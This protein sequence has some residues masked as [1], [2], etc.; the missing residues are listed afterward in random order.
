MAKKSAKSK[1]YRKSAPKKNYLSKKELTITAIVAAVVI[2][3]LVLFIG[4]Y[5]DGSLKVSGG[6]VKSSGENSLIV[7]AGTGYKPRYFQLGNLAEIDG[8]TLTVSPLDS[9]GNVNE[10]IYTP[11]SESPIDSI[12]VRT[13][14]LDAA[15]Y[16]SASAE[17]YTTDPSMNC[18][19]LHT[20][21]DDGHAV[22][23][24]TF[25]VTPSTNETAPTEL[26][27]SIEELRDEIEA[28][29]VIDEEEQATLELLA[30]AAKPMLAQALHGYID[31][32]ENRLIYVLIRNDVETEQEYAE[33]AVLV[34]ALNQILA[35]L[36]YETK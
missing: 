17:N 12:S 26:L 23:Y 33:D 7:N 27:E 9:N 16:A 29:G 19:G 18:D 30:E 4:F 1:G 31:A 35:A 32:G 3:A 28:D 36:S 20:T 8:Y 21:E 13:Y 2:V 14:A 24:L 25:S 6:K 22:S 34:D 15:T 11:D 10:F 5:D